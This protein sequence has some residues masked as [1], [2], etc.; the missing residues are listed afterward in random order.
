MDEWTWLRVPGT[1]PRS[2]QSNKTQSHRPDLFTS[3]RSKRLRENWGA[4]VAKHNK[5]SQYYS[6]S[7]EYKIDDNEMVSGIQM[8]LNSIIQMST[9]EYSSEMSR[10]EYSSGMSRNEPLSIKIKSNILIKF[11]VAQQQFF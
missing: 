1:S 8:S 5:V 6:P 10:K 11:N 4:V 3:S 2:T 9:N 7:G